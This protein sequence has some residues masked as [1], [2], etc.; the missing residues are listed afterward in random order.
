MFKRTTFYLLAFVAL[1]IG[2]KNNNSTSSAATD[3]NVGKGNDGYAYT[4]PH[5]NQWELGD[6]NN[7]KIAL[8]SL[9]AYE[10]GNISAAFKDYADTVLIQMDGFDRRLSKDSL[11][12]LFL[13][14]RA[15]IKRMGIVMND[16]VSLRSKDGRNDYVSL[17]Y[18]QL[19]EDQSGKVDSIECMD[20][21]AFKNGKIILWNEKVRRFSDILK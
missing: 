14:E 17:W 4:I 12:A 11:L 16:F 19:W 5:P 1:L 9:K 20:D 18:K 8:N 13:R 3:E 15:S 7:I 6:N 10:N 2:C 21:L